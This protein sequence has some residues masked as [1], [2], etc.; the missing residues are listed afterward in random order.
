M[1]IK[2]TLVLIVLS[3]FFVS[4]YKD[5][6]NY[7]YKEITPLLITDKGQ[8]EKIFIR[9]GEKLL[10]TP[11]V[12]LNGNTNELTFEWFVYLNSA[13]ASYVQD[14]T[15][16]STQQVLDY[17]VDPTIFNIGEDYKLT[18]KVTHR[19][20]GLS[21]FYFYQLTVADLFT[22]GWVFLQDKSN[23]A[24]LSMILKNGDIYHNIY[25]QRNPSHPIRNPKSLT[26]SP[27]SISDG[28]SSD[29]KKFYIVGKDDAIELNGT[30]MQKRFDFEY[31]FFTAPTGR[32]ASYIAWA[33]SDGNNLGVLINAGNLHTNIV[34][35]FPG[36][37]KFGPQLASPENSYDY[38]LAPQLISGY[39]Y[40]DT[41]NIIMYDQRNK[42]FYDVTSTALKKFDDAAMDK[43]IFDMNK[44]DLDLIKLDSSN[45]LTMRNAIMKDDKGAGF[46]L[47]F[48][49]TRT[50]GMPIITV[51][52][53]QIN[54][55]EIAAATDVSCSTLSPHLYY[56]TGPKLYC[57][58]V[59]SDTY[60][61][62]HNF[63][64]EMVT[65]VKFEKHGY[66]NAKPRLIVTTWDG[67]E[68]K[69]YFFKL[70]TDGRVGALEKTIKGFGKIIDLAFKY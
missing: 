30:T 60:A 68:G 32:Q 56:A 25:S 34:G 62:A 24:E 61:L 16:I 3:T 57:Y 13:S 5:K 35:G 10:L 19:T 58:E 33:G 28:V 39:L 22:T 70:E 15:K 42:R 66:G 27:R 31:L 20:T 45:V 21:Y 48:N 6:G 4:C 37:K 65:R 53:Q 2:Y 51:N 17:V 29:G 55:P 11:D 69:V 12:N 18:Y 49:T 8:T 23:L 46:L 63:G 64:A 26:I 44:V 43:S 38:T 36:A 14:S 47:Q 9:Q 41:Y 50:S 67:N 7:D 1:K 52:K 54:S 59:P 40:S